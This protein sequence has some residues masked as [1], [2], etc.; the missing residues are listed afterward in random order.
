M[1]LNLR[2]TASEIQTKPALYSQV[3]KEYSTED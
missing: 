2:D 3:M 1:F